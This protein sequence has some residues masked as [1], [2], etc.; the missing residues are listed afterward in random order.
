MEYILD[1]LKDDNYED[2]IICPYCRQLMWTKD[3]Y[4]EAQGRDTEDMLAR[5]DDTSLCHRRTRIYVDSGKLWEN[6]NEIRRMM[7]I[8]MDYERERTLQKIMLD[9]LK[10]DL[11]NMGG[12]TPWLG[13]LSERLQEM[14]MERCRIHWSGYNQACEDWSVD[15]DEI[16]E[17]MSLQWW[18]EKVIRRAIAAEC[19]RQ[20]TDDD[21]SPPT[22][23]LNLETQEV[24]LLDNTIVRTLS[25]AGR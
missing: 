23:F 1:V 21:S 14:A 19:K 18:F 22:A 17:P 12:Q 3:E 15:N 16:E 13:V 11:Q 25:E 5:L 2:S 4:A 20:S 7:N 24:V 9:G 8:R 6:A 10:S